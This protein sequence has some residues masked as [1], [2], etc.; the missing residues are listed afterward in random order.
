MTVR[1]NEVQVSP[2]LNIGI[3]TTWPWAFWAVYWTERGLPWSF[4]IPPLK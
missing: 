4:R 3:F 2:G 1:L